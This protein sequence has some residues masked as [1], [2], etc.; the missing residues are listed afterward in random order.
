MDLVSDNSSG[1][2]SESS[3]WTANEEVNE[4]LNG[5]QSSVVVV[6]GREGGRGSKIA[7]S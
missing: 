6:G 5:E 1:H 3:Q 2:M 7:P 4:P